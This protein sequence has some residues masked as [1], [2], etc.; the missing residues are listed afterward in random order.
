LMGVPPAAIMRNGELQKK[1]ERGLSL[2]FSGH[3]H[4]S[5]RDLVLQP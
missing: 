3:L 5:F 2:F 4:I 1:S